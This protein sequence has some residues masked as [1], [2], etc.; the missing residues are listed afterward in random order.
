MVFKQLRE[1]MKSR[2]S[3]KKQASLKKS[4]TTT[5][6][7]RPWNKKSVDRKASTTKSVPAP[8]PPKKVAEAPKKHAPPAIPQPVKEES[9]IQPPN[10]LA[11]VQVP[12]EDEVSSNANVDECPG[13]FDYLRSREV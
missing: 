11:F 3:D 12:S 10:E 8:L 4:K 2:R 9:P 13:A 7:P 5:P 1:T 6:R